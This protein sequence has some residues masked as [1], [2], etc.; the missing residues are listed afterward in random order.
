MKNSG[1]VTKHK[2]GFQ[3]QFIR[4]LPFPQHVVWEAIT[5][6]EKLSAWFTDVEMDF[7][8]GG[9]IVIRFRDENKT[10]SFGKIT[11]IEPPRLFE[12]LWEDELATWEVIPDG[13]NSKLVLT[14]SKLPDSYAVSVPA[15]WHVL[16]DQLEEVLHGSSAYYPFGG[17]ETETGRHMKAK[18]EDLVTSQYPELKH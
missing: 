5:N 9:K 3:V 1:I 10:E 11:R 7:K 13:K 16:L 15:G 12:Y 2:D 14:Y 8:P 6:T 18:Y 4:M 17:E